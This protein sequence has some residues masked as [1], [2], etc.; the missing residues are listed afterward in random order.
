MSQRK[1]QREQAQRKTI[2]KS[3]RKPEPTTS[4]VSD[5]T[6]ASAQPIAEQPAEPPAS[7][8]SL[9]QTGAPGPDHQALPETTADAAASDSVQPTPASARPA[10]ATST[11]AAV[12]AKPQ[13]D[14]ATE[15]QNRNAAR[16]IIRILNETQRQPMTQI[17]QIIEHLGSDF[18]Y[19]MLNKTQEID[20]R[21]GMMLGDGSRPRTIGGIFFL[22]VREWLQAE[23]Q[24]DMLKQIFPHRRIIP[25]GSFSDRPRPPQPPP[26]PAATWEDRGPLITE[27][28]QEQ[29]QANNIRVTLMGR[30]LKVVER[31]RFTIVTM[32]Q[33][34]RLTSLPR[35][36]P[37]PEKVFQTIYV[38][39]I[40]SR[41]W[42]RLK[43]ALANPED[44]AIIEGTQFY[45]PEYRTLSVLAINCTTRFMEQ[46]RRE[47][48]RLQRP[49]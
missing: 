48:Q 13:P 47:E 20:S 11:D 43:Q 14:A 33:I 42:R 31:Q 30:F 44:V 15:E 1:R 41:Q 22:L 3:S 24:I 29:G 18:A 19:E 9:E 37:A 38:V 49:A 7:P 36:L 40:G 8:A 17:K 2:R 34:E 25:P 35:G 10:L 27:V 23:G 26:L 46:E 45:D 6:D 16:Q 4:E 39:F 21:G 5:L 32:K 12:Q 28:L